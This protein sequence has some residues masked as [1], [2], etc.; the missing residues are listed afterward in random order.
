MAVPT[1]TGFLCTFRVGE[2]GLPPNSPDSGTTARRTALW[3][4]DAVRD[5]PAP[6]LT[7]PAAFRHAVVSESVLHQPGDFHIA[8]DHRPSH[9]VARQRSLQPLG[10][11]RFGHVLVPERFAEQRKRGEQHRM[12]DQRFRFEL[13]G[14]HGR[15]LRQ[16]DLH[17]VEGP[18]RRAGGSFQFRWISRG[19]ALASQRCHDSAVHRAPDQRHQLGAERSR[20]SLGRCGIA[21]SVGDCRSAVCR[22][23]YGR[24]LPDRQHRQQP[25]EL[26]REQ[27]EPLR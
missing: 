25:S 8:H 13:H 4:P 22:R 18:S 2:R 6:E 1:A 7:A 24:L 19:Y 27:L 9:V 20:R 11:D 16:R 23:Q 15:L 5:R 14:H 17:H 10:P 12:P 21:E 3:V 26:H